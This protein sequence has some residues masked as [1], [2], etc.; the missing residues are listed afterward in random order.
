MRFVR[1]HEKRGFKHSAETRAKISAFQKGRAKPRGPES[2]SFG[3]GCKTIRGRVYIFVGFD[4]P[5]ATQRGFVLEHRLVASMKVG[6]MLNK[7]EHVHHVDLDPTNNDPSNL[8]V[9]DN[10][11]H[12][13][14]HWKIQRDGLDPRDAVR[15]VLGEGAL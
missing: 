9:V 11:Q 6:R 7:S 5:M 12:K 4:H 1:G 8:V 10:V 13:Q 2:S 15:A 3:G 14:I